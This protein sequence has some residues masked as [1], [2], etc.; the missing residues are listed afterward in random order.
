[1]SYLSTLL[2]DFKQ[3]ALRGNMIDLAV[4][5]II[6]AKFNALV[7]A[8][9]DDL[10]MPPIS[11]LLGR[12]SF[13]DVEIPIGMAP[14]LDPDGTP[15]LDEAGEPIL[16]QSAI[17]VGEFLQ[18]G[19]NFLVIAFCVFLIVRMVNKAQTALMDNDENEA[20][21]KEKN[22]P[23]DVQLLR[24]IRDELRQLSE[25]PPARNRGNEATPRDADDSRDAA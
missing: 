13:E 8:M 17:E 10:I 19:F 5:I 2:D 4:G 25:H 15:A 18:V 6:G 9:V 22:T 3:F 20:A 24:Q 7:Q 23:E 12:A 21:P 16:V 11:K 1:M 14:K